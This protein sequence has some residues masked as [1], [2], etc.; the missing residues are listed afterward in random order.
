ML[1]L[2][3]PARIETIKEKRL[4]FAC[5]RS[6]HISKYCTRRMICS[7]CNKRHPTMLRVEF[8]DNSSP[9][10]DHH[11]EEKIY[12]KKHSKIC[13]ETKIVDSS[14]VPPVLPV[15]ISVSGENPAKTYAFLD[16]GSQST[17]ITEDLRYK[18]G[19]SGNQTTLK[20]T[21]V[22][23]TSNP[24][25]SRIVTGLHVSDLYGKNTLP[26]PPMY[27]IANIPIGNEDIPKKSLKKTWPYL[28]MDI[29]EVKAE[30]IG[31]LIGCDCPKAMEPWHVIH[32]QNGGPY[33]LKTCL[34]WTVIGPRKRP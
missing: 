12:Q 30:E 31:I 13:G 21:T 15:Q 33:A 34:G 14:A 1:Q 27:T 3:M 20:I 29:P 8:K 23:H 22:E 2:D 9:A 5:L 6:N 28:E 18:L 11:N 19:Q 24:L 25:R 7:K 32:S 17:F 10:K 16:N 26:L 4:C